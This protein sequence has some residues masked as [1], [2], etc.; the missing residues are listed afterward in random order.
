MLVSFM[1]E[2]SVNQVY[3]HAPQTKQASLNVELDLQI[4]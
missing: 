3:Y 4:I 2:A 1:I